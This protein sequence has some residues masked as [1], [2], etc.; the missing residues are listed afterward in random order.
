MVVQSDGG[1][2]VADGV[3]SSLSAL[4]ARVV[5]LSVDP[6]RLVRPELAELLSGYREESVAGVVSLLGMATQPHPRY[7]CV[8][9]G[10]AASMVLAQAL[11]DSELAAPLWLVTQGAVA[12]SDVDALVS[13]AQGAVW[14]LG[15]VIGLEYP[16][17]WGG[18]IDLPTK[19]DPNSWARFAA[20]LAGGGSEDQ[21]AV[22]D[23]GLLV[24]RLIRARANASKRTW[25][26]HGTVLITGGTGALGAH[27]ARWAAANGAEHVVLTSRRGM[28][29]PGVDALR[30]ELT[31]SGALVSV[32]ACD[33][34]DREA[35]ARLLAGLDQRWPLTA[36]VHAAG[37]GQLSPLNQTD[38]DAL[39][40][41][42]G[43]KL[44][45]AVHLDALLGDGQ[46]DAFVLF[47]SIAATWGSG[48]QSGYAAANAMLDSLAHHRRARGLTATSIAWGPW[49]EGGMATG[50]AQTELSRRGLNAMSPAAAIAAFHHAIDQ[51]ETCLTIADVTWKHFAPTYASARPRPLLHDI[52]DAHQALHTTPP[53]TTTNGLRAHL[54]TLPPTEQHRHL[55]D[56]IRTHAAAV[57]GHPNT[58]K[59]KPQRA[60]KELGF[61]SI[62]A[63]ELR[64]RLTTTT[65]L[66]LPTTLIFDHP[67]PTTLAEHV[68]FLLDLHDTDADRAIAPADMW[69]RFTPDDSDSIVIV[70][71]ACRYPGG[72]GTAEELWEHGHCWPRRH[73]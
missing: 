64:N 32:L 33:M 14:G 63:I 4:G 35:V 41:V 1:D 50:E 24:R 43:G 2:A 52:P 28:Q 49:A 40:D 10:T 44:A 62:T 73:R 34:A 68:A 42:V 45:G 54:L 48:G 15:R 31:G 5:R 55:T 59:V 17:G 69:T 19:V 8:P 29:A 51:N 57:L 56:L 47:S 30:E 9:V 36:V 12:T 26:P 22:R 11:Q 7:P 60:F 21:V 39:A 25:R 67:N 16:H 46:L 27:V 65:G 38:L 58:D 71:M 37:V 72:V 53:P 6:V 20:M 13:V 18:L 66:T 3:E 61:D 70:G 23:G